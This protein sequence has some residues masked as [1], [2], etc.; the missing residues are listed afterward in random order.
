MAQRLRAV[1]VASALMSC[2]VLQDAYAL[3]ATAPP[4]A[5]A[6]VGPLFGD[7]G[8]FCT[9]SV[10]HS[11]DRSLIVTA[12]HCLA[13]G[14]EVSF[15][16]G[17]RDGRAPYGFWEVERVFADAAWRDG[18]DEDHDLAFATVRPRDGR[19]IEDVTGAGPLATDGRA[20]REVTVTG[21][22]SAEEAPRVCTATPTAF[23]GTQQRIACPGFST[24]TSG[25]PWVDAGGRITGV[26][27]GY[28][29]GGDSPDVS[30]SV[31]LDGRAAA[32]YREATRTP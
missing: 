24:G 16:P 17:Y 28:Q 2:A 18:E 32:L 1:L 22:P 12:A 31:L 10:V 21:Y 25:S 6:G 19:R 14:D 7:D 29:E 11:P 15:A 23:H 4:P 20:G 8:H 3:D 9:A 27:G 30:Y 26:L 5:S 13:D